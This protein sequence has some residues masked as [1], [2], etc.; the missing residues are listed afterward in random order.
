VMDRT[1]F[2]GR[3]YPTLYCTHYRELGPERSPKSAKI[4]QG[5]YV[6]LKL[7]NGGASRNRLLADP[8]VLVG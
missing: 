8:T 5:E 6:I 7:A 1:T 3:I 4:A 2:Q